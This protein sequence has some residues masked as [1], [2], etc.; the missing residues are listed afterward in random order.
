MSLTTFLRVFIRSEAETTVPGSSKRVLTRFTD[1]LLRAPTDDRPLVS[2]GICFYLREPVKHRHFH[3]S[4]WT[5]AARRGGV[6]RASNFS[7]PKD[8][9]AYTPPGP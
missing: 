6:T 4:W 3:P 8:S 7:L 1:G 2:Q 9:I 5:R